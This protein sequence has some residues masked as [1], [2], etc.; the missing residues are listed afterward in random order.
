MLGTLRRGV[1][2][3]AV[4]GFAYGLFV[5]LVLHPLAEVAEGL[6]ANAHGHDHLGSGGSE[7][8]VAEA[9]TMAVSAGGGVLWGV[10]LGAGFGVAYYL[11]E[12]ALPGGEHRAYVLAGAGFLT[13]SAAPWLVLPPMGA[14]TETVLAIG[15]RLVV[16]AGMMAVGAVAAVAAVVAYNRLAA[17]GRTVALAGAAVPLLVLAGIGAVAPS[18]VVTGDAPAELVAAFGWLVAFG[19]VSLW[20]LLAAA[21]VRLEGVVGVDGTTIDRAGSPAD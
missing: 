2:A 18:V 7:H 9:T 6:A 3:G 21:F 14:G 13:V 20:A 15:P 19:Q 16:Y 5:L 17:R 12:P 4:A 8:A 10:L 1:A 11:F